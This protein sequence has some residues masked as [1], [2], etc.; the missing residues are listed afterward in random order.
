MSYFR[1]RVLQ[2]V[3]L[4]GF[5]ENPAAL[6][7]RSALW[8][9]YCGIGYSPRFRLIDEVWFKV[10]PVLRLSG[11]TSA[12][13]MRH[14]A[15]PELH[16]LDRLVGEHGVFIDCG[17]NIGIYTV[18][19]AAIVGSKGKVIS[20]EPGAVSFKR[21]QRNIGLNE[22]PQVTLVN[23]AVSDTEDTARLYHADGG[24]VAFSLVPKPNTDFEEV[25]TTT[26]DSLVEENKMNRVDCI[27]LDVEG[28]EV[29]ALR[30]AK[31]TLS[32]LR[33]HVI[34]ERT[35]PGQQ[36]QAMSEETP[37]LIMSLGYR[38]YRYPPRRIN[39][40]IR[41]ES[42]NV[43]AIHPDSGRSVP[44]FLEAWSPIETSVEDVSGISK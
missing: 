14:W 7:A 6:L 22:F 2:L 39:S 11:S 4:P 12:F 5:H 35:S 8:L 41:Y 3:S 40:Q 32:R 34:F 9:I 20:V 10:D 26:I 21:L 30:G 1:E 16:Y 17:A 25:R 23:K 44:A 28:A 37:S 43:V 36:R 18:R 33:P 29:P 15:E 13:V 19:G 42:P 24:P 27:K 38:L 31:Q